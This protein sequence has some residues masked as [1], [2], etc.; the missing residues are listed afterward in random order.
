M[1][2]AA[3]SGSFDLGAEALSFTPIGLISESMGIRQV[4]Y[5]E[6]TGDDVNHL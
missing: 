6:P 5:F 4:P 3:I 2:P 1:D